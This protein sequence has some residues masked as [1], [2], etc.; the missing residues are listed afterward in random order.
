MTFQK[1]ESGNPAGRPR[2]VRDKRSVLAEQLLEDDADAIVRKA[3]DLAKTGDGGALK[4]C[5]ERICPSLKQRP[6]MFELPPMQS[7]A[8]A[9]AGIAAITQGL[10]E[11]TLTA[12]EAADL[13]KMVGIFAEALALSD[14]ENRIT[15]LEE[16]TK[17]REAKS[18]LRVAS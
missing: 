1:G 8:D 18:G 2:G 11:G 16:I 3:I 5:I 14:I 10:A 13:S 7:A 17:A 12:G 4:L 15:K 9:A 6:L